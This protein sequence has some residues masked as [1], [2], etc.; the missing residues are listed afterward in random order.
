M[1][2]QGSVKFFNAQKG[3][4]FILP[5]GGGED[6]FV[7]FSVINNDGFKTLNEG[8]TVFYDTQ[9]DQQKGKVCA[10]NVTGQGDGIP[11]QNKGKGGKDF[12]GKGK[13]GKDFGGKGFVGGKGGFDG[14]KGGFDGGKGGFDGGKGFDGGF[15]GKGMGKFDG[16]MG[17]GMGKGFDGGMYW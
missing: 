2:Q 14:G 1:S 4:G 17:K 16:G 11:A 13:G 8:E 12:G 6:I 9:Y 7:H 10:T 15:G 3:F 5:A